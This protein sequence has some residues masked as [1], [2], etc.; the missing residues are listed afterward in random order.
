MIFT[1]H[2]VVVLYLYDF[3]QQRLDSEY[4]SDVLD[5]YELLDS[6][7][8]GVVAFVEIVSLWPDVELTL[9]YLA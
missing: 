1:L 3:Y 9:E 8:K 5:L 4:A 6:C 2:T 7:V